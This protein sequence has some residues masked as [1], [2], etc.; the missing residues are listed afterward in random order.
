ML[1]KKVKGRLDCSPEACAERNRQRAAVKE[2][3]DLGAVTGPARPPRCKNNGGIVECKKLP[4]R[5]G[6]CD[7]CLKHGVPK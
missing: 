2:S 3:A 7:L 5:Q 4:L 6:R 1:E